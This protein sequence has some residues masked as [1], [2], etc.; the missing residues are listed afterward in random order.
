MSN[1]FQFN[2]VVKILEHAAK[3]KVNVIFA[4][5][6]GLSRAGGSSIMLSPNMSLEQMERKLCS[7]LDSLGKPYLG[8]IKE[9]E[10]SYKSCISESNN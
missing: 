8:L 5:R 9:L 3:N 7:V 2:R 10:S 6:L 1:D 4:E